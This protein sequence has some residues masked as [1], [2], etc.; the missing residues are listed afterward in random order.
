MITITSIDPNIIVSQIVTYNNIGQ[1][2]IEISISAPPLSDAQ[3]RLS[4]LETRLLT[5]ETQALDDMNLIN[6]NPA[7]KD[8][9]DKYK[10]MLTLMKEPA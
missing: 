10:V 4:D 3:S 8:L 2:V 1:P 9:Y 5:L 7:L 6:A